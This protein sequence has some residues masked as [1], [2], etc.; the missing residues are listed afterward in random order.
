MK[1]LAL[2]IILF[3]IACLLICL[4]WFLLRDKNAVQNPDASVSPAESMFY[5]YDGNHSAMAKDGVYDEY[6]S[7]N[8]S[9][10]QEAI[11]FKEILEGKR[12][13][14]IGSDKNG[15]DIK[16]AYC[17]LL[18]TLRQGKKYISYYKYEYEQ[19]VKIAVEY[20]SHANMQAL[21]DS[22][23]L[24]V[25]S[26]VWETLDYIDDVINCED[27]AFGL[28]CHILELQ[29]NTKDESVKA[30]AEKLSNKTY[31]VQEWNNAD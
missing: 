30:S 11:W 24:Y 27:Y 21:T 6:K 23:K 29:Q 4:L 8:V 17:N 28:R 31:S 19:I 14:V 2:P 16:I 13:E 3:I 1:K 5:V 10:E 18:A 9:K 25:Y 12:N 7:Y 22:S 20:L 26:A 15:D